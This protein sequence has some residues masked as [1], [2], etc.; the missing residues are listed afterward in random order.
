[1]GI[2]IKRHV[3]WIEYRNGIKR[4]RQLIHDSIDLHEGKP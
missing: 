4:V 2:K 1:M 3:Y